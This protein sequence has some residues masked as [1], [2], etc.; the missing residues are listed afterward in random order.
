MR[1]VRNIAGRGDQSVNPGGEY[2]TDQNKG[3]ENLHS[4]GQL[5]AQ[6][7]GGNNKRQQ[8]QYHKHR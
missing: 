4:P 8:P 5:H 6:H 7:V 1:N 2:R 3:R